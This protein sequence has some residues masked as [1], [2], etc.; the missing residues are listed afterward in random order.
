MTTRPETRVM[1]EAD[2]D[3]LAGA[4]VVITGAAKGIGEATGLVFGRRGADVISLDLDVPSGAD[5]G[6]RYLQVDVTDRDAMREAVASVVKETGRLD[7]LVNNAGIQRV[8]LIEEIDPAAWD[9]VVRV[10]LFG[11]YNGTAAA[12]EHMKARG[13]GAIVNIASV[14]GF[15]ALPGRSAYSAAKAG[16]MSLTRVTALEGAQHRIRVNAVAPGFTRTKLLQQGILDGSLKEDW[17]VAEVPLGRLAEPTEI[18]RAVAFLASSEA[19]YITGQTLLV[20][21]GWTI[22]G[23]HEKPDWLGA[24]T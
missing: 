10:H 23:I 18:G 14:A 8:G 4:T 20:D 16:I 15:L 2:I 9:L 3:P 5:T 13:G 17:M 1:E 7:V 6:F 22:Q 12:F 24:A 19:S 21:G 11:A